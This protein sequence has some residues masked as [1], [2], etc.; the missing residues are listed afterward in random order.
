EIDCLSVEATNSRIDFKT[1]RQS[2]FSI[3]RDLIVSIF[4]HLKE[5]PINAIGINHLCHYSLRNSTEYINFGYW[6]SPVE[7]LGSLLNRPKLQTIQ[8]VETKDNDNINNEGVIRLTISPSDLILDQKSVVL[9]SNHH[10]QNPK[11]TDA[12]EMISLMI[13]KWDFSFEKVN[14]LNN[15]IWEKAKY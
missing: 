7:Q 11:G 10:F 8:F 15:L 3:L 2:H 6:L 13:N 9:N 12:K 14:N 1:K 5:T 4:S